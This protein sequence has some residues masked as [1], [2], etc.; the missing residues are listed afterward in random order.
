MTPQPDWSESVN[1][2]KQ[3]NLYLK[4]LLFP[5]E[6]EAWFLVQRKVT[7]TWGKGTWMPSSAADLG[8]NLSHFLFVP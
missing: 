5:R 3:R 4:Q 8:F 7:I 1:M 2:M 6:A